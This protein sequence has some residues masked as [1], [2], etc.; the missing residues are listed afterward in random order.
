MAGG[1]QRRAAIVTEAAAPTVD[2]GATPDTVVVVE[3][4]G[5]RTRQIWLTL[6]VIAAA[7]LAHH[8]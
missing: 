4:Q 3:P 2:P 6:V 5:V 7:L 1:K 8:Q